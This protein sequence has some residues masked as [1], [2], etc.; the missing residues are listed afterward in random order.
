MSCEDNSYI[1][2]YINNIYR[3]SFLIFTIWLILDIYNRD[4]V[5]LFSYAC[6]QDFVYVSNKN[7]LKGTWSELKSE[8]R[9]MVQ[10]KLLM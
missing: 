5:K 1:I 4:T 8:K 2:Y 6:E 9:H 3:C 7:I 10:K